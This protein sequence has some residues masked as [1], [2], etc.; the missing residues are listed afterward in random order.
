MCADSTT[1]G[2]RRGKHTSASHPPKEPDKPVID[3]T[4]NDSSETEEGMGKAFPL[5]MCKGISAECKDRDCFAEW[6]LVEDS[7]FSY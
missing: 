3:A 7:E 6:S 2:C 1:Q 5:T 4:S